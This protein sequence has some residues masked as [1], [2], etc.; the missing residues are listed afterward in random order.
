MP[1]LNIMGAE[2]A[3]DNLTVNAQG[4]N[5]LLDAS[6]LP[7]NLIGLTLNGGAGNDTILGGRGNDFVSGG[8]GNDV[9]MLGSGDDTFLWNLGDGSDAIDGGAGTDTMVFNGSNTGE[10]IDISA[11]GRDVRFTRNIAN[12]VMELSSVERADFNALGGADTITVNDLTG[13]ELTQI[14][15]DLSSGA[16]PGI[17]D[18]LADDVIVNGTGGDD[19]I[20]IADNDR[21][22]SVVGLPAQVNIRGADAAIDVLTINTLGGDD[23]L[24]AT[25]LSDAAISLVADGGDGDDELIGGAGNDSLIG[26]AGNDKLNGE[27]GDDTLSGGAG[28]DELTGGPGLDVL[29]GGPGNDILI[30]D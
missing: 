5:D 26:G 3:N 8:P 4:G 2:A 25:S 18:G 6:N 24:D 23:S 12:V 16:S 30:Q 22:V 11:D 27:A 19:D 29:D 9:A 17:G 28:D 21:G 14:N 10:L 15:V 13:T 20:T 7:A 1:A